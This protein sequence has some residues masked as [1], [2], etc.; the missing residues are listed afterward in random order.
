MFVKWNVRP[1]YAPD[2]LSGGSEGGGAAD[3]PK[4]GGDQPAAGS[5]GGKAPAVD[6]A[7]KVETPAAGA[8]PAKGS[9]QGKSATD[10]LSLS[11][12]LRAKLIAAL[13]KEAQERAGKYV[14]SRSSIADL[15]KAGLGADSKISELMAAQKGLIKP[16]GEKATPEEVAAYRKAVGVP[17]TADKYAV[18]RPEGF[19]PTEADTEAEKTFLEAAHA[20]NLNQRQVDGVMK[21]YYLLQAQAAKAQSDRAAAAAEKAVEDL[22]VEFGRDYKAN[23]ALADRWLKE[24]LGEDM[25]DDW[26][27]LMGMRFQDGTALGEHTGFVKAIVKLAKA[28]ADDGLPDIGEGGSGESIDQQVDSMMKKMGTDEYNS[29]AFQQKLQ[30]L[31]AQQNKRRA[32]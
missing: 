21:T 17:E 25:G 12:E 8:D 1:M 19:E 14:K 15:L 11:D 3:E 9:E 30:A 16:L 26:K 28:W 5:D 31:I 23:V 6:P 7:G 27:G 32:A 10:D 13:P 22:R 18:Y 29:P 20:A 4:V 24:H 2:D